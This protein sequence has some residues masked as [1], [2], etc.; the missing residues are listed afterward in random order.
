MQSGFDSAE[1]ILDLSHK[2]SQVWGDQGVKFCLQWLFRT[3]WE[4][5]F[6]ISNPGLASFEA[7]VF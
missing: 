1:S 2:F 5:V 7:K 6:I 3:V 4:S